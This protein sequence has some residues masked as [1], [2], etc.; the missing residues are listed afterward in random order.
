MLHECRVLHPTS[1]ALSV[2]E[3][4]WRVVLLAAIWAMEQGRKRLWSLIQR[5]FGRGLL[6]S[7]PF[8][9]LPPPFGLP[10]MIL[11]DWPVP[12]KG[13]DEIGPDHPSLSVRIQIPL[14]PCLAITLPPWPLPRCLFSCN[15]LCGERYCHTFESDLVRYVWLHFAFVLCF[16]L[17][18]YAHL[19]WLVAWDILPSLLQLV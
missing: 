15:S 4:I 6:C 9:K 14:R 3:M 5:L 11:L 18:G 12:V 2:C 19:A 8:P 7:R 10:C 17:L 1:P 13:W 16:A